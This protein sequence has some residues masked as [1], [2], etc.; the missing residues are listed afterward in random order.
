MKQ[1]I[2]FNENANS[3]INNPDERGFKYIEWDIKVEII[4]GH[5]RNKRI[6]RS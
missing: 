4:G 2:C 3:F 6:I 5:N 1:K